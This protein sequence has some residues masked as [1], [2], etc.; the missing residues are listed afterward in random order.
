MRIVAGKY[1]G[2]NLVTP[3]NREIRPTTDRVRESLFSILESGY[4]Q[5][6]SNTRTLDLFA[7]TGALGLEAISRGVEFAVFVESSQQGINLIRKNIEL[8]G[9]GD[10]TKVIRSDAALLGPVG[11]LQPFNLVFAD[12]PYNKGN[13]DKALDCLIND[14]WLCQDALIIIEESADS[15]PPQLAHCR[16]LD[17]RK[18][19]DTKIWISEVHV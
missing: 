7:G 3:D 19:G 17:E 1:R 10:Q 13:A 2:R 9:A 8:L 16:I 5:Y 6:L 14:G 11:S 15:P 4:S 12:P 18:F